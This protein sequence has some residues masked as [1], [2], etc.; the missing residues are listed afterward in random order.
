MLAVLLGFAPSM[1]VSFSRLK[2]ESTEAAVESS[3][4]QPCAEAIFRRSRNMP[5]QILLKACAASLQENDD[6]RRRTGGSV[7]RSGRTTRI[8]DR[9]ARP[10]GRRLVVGDSGR[11]RRRRLWRKGL[12]R[13]AAWPY[14]WE[15]AQGGG[16]LPVPPARRDALRR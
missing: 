8:A 10:V 14:A 2:P 15:S 1:A 6:G 13:A 9:I 3:V 7:A 16:A 12:W 4:S 11:L 5:F